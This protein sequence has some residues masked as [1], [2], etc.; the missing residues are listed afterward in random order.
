MVYIK[1]YRES[2]TKCKIK[3]YNFE[4]TDSSW[5]SVKYWG[6]ILIITS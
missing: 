1:Y 3:G 5:Y 4:L 6:L 2:F